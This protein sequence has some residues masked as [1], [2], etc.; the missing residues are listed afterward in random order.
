MGNLKTYT[1]RAFRPIKGYNKFVN[2]SR[3]INSYIAIIDVIYIGV[4]FGIFRLTNQFI[5]IFFM[6][7]IS[8]I[9]I[10]GAFIVQTKQVMRFLYSLV[11]IIIALILTLIILLLLIIRLTNIYS[12]CKLINDYHKKYPELDNSII[13]RC[14]QQKRYYFLWMGQQLFFS[15]SGIIEIYFAFIAH[16]VLKEKEKR[17]KI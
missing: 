7:G 8:I 12:I 1:V 9:K 16:N 4:N 15:S 13:N 2:R 6:T 5:L 17:K 10:I 14:G 3:V 11:L